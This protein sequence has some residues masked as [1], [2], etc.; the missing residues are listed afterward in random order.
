M[1][2]NDKQHLD[3]WWPVAG[4]PEQAE[5]GREAALRE[6]QEETGLVPLEVYEFGMEIPHV[7]PD[8]R[9]ETFVAVV[10]PA[11]EIQLNYEHSDYQWVDGEGA[12]AIVPEHSRTYLRHLKECFM[13]SGNLV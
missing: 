7:N 4:K 6:L 11:S 12:V 13:D 10:D 1:K 2:R 9:L 8:C 3:S 5:T